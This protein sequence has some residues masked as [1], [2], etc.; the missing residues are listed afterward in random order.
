MFMCKLAGILDTKIRTLCEHVIDHELQNAEGVFDDKS[1]HMV[2]TTIM[3]RLDEDETFGHVQSKRS[4]DLPYRGETLL[5]VPVAC[6]ADEVHVRLWARVKQMAVAQGLIDALQAETIMGYK[7]LPADSTPVLAPELMVKA[8]GEVIRIMIGCLVAWRLGHSSVP[9]CSLQL[10]S[11]QT[12]IWHAVVSKPSC[13]WASI[14]DS[15][16]LPFEG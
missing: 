3:N 6:L 13:H 15:S 14:H 2:H 10:T 7:T 16:A 4:I 12:A 9:N 11:L 1:M 5:Q 8:R